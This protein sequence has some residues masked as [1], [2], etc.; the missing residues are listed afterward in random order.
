[1]IALEIVAT[2]VV[3][4]FLLIY[5]TITMEKDRRFNPKERAK[6]AGLCGAVLVPAVVG[7]AASIDMTFSLRQDRDSHP[8]NNQTNGQQ[9]MTERETRDYDLV[10]ASILATPGMG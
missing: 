10:V 6:I 2:Q 4:I 9:K 8:Q 5:T 3:I 1:M 7:I